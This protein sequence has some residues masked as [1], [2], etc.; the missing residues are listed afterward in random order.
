MMDR[1]EINSHGLRRARTRQ[2][3]QLGGLIAKAG[4]LET[5]QISLGA[6]LQKDPETKEP[7]ASLF[8][9][10]LVLN[11]MANSSEVNLSLWAAQGLEE[12]RKS[13]RE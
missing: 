1:L 5:F 11:E 3:V 2:Y 13:N 12:L 9:G 4:L 10:L 8:K 6:D 7:V